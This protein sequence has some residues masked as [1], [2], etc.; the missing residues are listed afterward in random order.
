MSSRRRVIYSFSTFTFIFA[1]TNDILNISFGIKIW[2][3]FHHKLK[4][5]GFV[6]LEMLPSLQR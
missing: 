4:I 6:H 5:P 2:S 1:P 3:S